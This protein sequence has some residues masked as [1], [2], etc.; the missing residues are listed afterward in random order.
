MDGGGLLEPQLVVDELGGNAALD[1]VV[2]GGAE[3]AGS[4]LRRVSQVRRGVGGRDHAHAGIGN[5]GGADA[6]FAGA[7][8]AHHGEE[9]GVR[10]QL[11]GSRLAAFGAAA[12]VLADDLDLVAQQFAAHIFDS[13]FH[14]ALRIDAERAIGARGDHGIRNFDRLAGGDCH[15]AKRVRTAARGGRGRFGR[16]LS[17]SLGCRGIGRRSFGC[18]LS[19]RGG[20]AG[21]R[22][23]S[24]AATGS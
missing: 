10:G 7:G 3:V 8:G 21:G 16:C 14:A 5:D 6:R 1:L 18:S 17:C 23:R 12:G 22:C 19:G 13:D 15:A 9:A 24:S 20:F 4:P 11:R 2:V